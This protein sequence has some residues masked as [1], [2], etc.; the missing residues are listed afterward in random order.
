MFYF[1]LP[2]KAY[3]EQRELISTLKH[4]SGMKF[5]LKPK[6]FLTGNKMLDIAALN[7]HDLF[8]RNTCVSSIHLNRP[9]W[10]K[11]SLFSKF[12]QLIC[13]MYSCQKLIEF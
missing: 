4:L 1:N 12:K 6:S 7:I 3:M 5:L 9:V 13:R 8:C 11:Q 2:V 10:K